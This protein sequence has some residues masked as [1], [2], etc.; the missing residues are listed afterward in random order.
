MIHFDWFVDTIKP[1]F[2]LYKK[3]G[4]WKGILF[5]LFFCQQHATRRRGLETF[6]FEFPHTKTI[7]CD[8]IYPCP[9]Q[10]THGKKDVLS[11]ICWTFSG[12]S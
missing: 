5:A 1:G 8:F 7:A 3:S 2:Q 10:K 12:E 11:E 4:F 9:Q 6:F